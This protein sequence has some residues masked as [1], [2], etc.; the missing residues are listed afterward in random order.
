MTKAPTFTYIEFSRPRVVR[1]RVTLVGLVGLNQ[2]E[3]KAAV[4]RFANAL[5]SELGEHV[6]RLH[7]TYW[8]AKMHCAKERTT[9]QAND[10]AIWERALAR[11]T[12]VAMA[13]LVADEVVYFEVH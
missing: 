9:R 6:V 11:A 13:S 2:N 7:A 5:D 1:Y 12:A 10:V 3:R 4:L 8:D